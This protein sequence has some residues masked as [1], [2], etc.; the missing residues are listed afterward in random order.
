MTEQQIR[1]AFQRYL[2]RFNVAAFLYKIDVTCGQPSCGQVLAT[3]GL[4]HQICAEYILL[5]EL[6][7]Q[8]VEMR[9]ATE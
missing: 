7:W 6:M 4:G 8:C 1:Q 3:N 5:P 9:E 2:V